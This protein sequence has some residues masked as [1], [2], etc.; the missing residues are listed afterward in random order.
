[1]SAFG[2]VAFLIAGALGAQLR[3]VVTGVVGERTA[4]A[5]PWATLLINVTGSLV[6]GLLTGLALYHGLATTASTTLGVGFCGAY[7]TFST[8]TFETVALLEQGAVCEALL[9]ALGTLVACA[10]AGALGMAVAAL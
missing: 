1:V 8:F 5:F 4:G 10:A 6:L 7:T 9:A 3:Y 2:W